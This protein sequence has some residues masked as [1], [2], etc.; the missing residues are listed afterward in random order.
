MRNIK[1]TLLNSAVTL[2]ATLA[3]VTAAHADPP[4]HAG[5]PHKDK[6][7]AAKH[8][9]K[10]GKAQDR[11]GIDIDIVF[12]SPHRAIIHDYYRGEFSQRGC[13]PGLAK[14]GNGCMPPGQARKWS[15][16]HRL[17][18][19]IVYYPLPHDLQMRLGYD[20]P[21]YKLIRVGADILRIGVGSAI[22]VEAVEDLG[23][24]F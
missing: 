14:K 21:A 8:A 12:D 7:S 3:L 13:P 9:G 24:A 17:P 5:G 16:G 19:D 1:Y 10:S 18:D 20:D 15:L 4:A 6:S 22:V 23:G 11:G 2:L